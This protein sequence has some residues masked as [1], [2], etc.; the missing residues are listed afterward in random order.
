MHRR[1]RI[2]WWIPWLIVL[3]LMSAPAL[4]TAQTPEPAASPV[5]DSSQVAGEWVARANDQRNG[6]VG[7]APLVG[8]PEILWTAER[9]TP[10]YLPPAVGDDIL[11]VQSEDAVAAL[12]RMTGE[13]LWESPIESSGSAPSLVDGV[14]YTGGLQ[15]A[16]AI[17]AR[18]GKTIWTF[19]PVHELEG[20]PPADFLP[21]TIVDA[22]VAVINGTVF[23]SGGVYGGLW[24]LDAA[25]GQEK[26]FYDT[27]GGMP[28]V[29]S[30]VDGTLYLTADS[31][32]LAGMLAGSTVSRLQA[33]DAAT[34]ELA[35]STELPP[36]TAS[37]T[38]PIVLGDTL[39]IGVSTPIPYIGS[40][41][42]YDRLTGTLLWNTPYPIPP[43]PANAAAK[44]GLFFVPGA[45][46]G[47]V[48]ALDAVT[49]DV[50][51][52]HDSPHMAWWGMIVAGDVLY[53][54]T[55]EPAIEALDTATGALLWSLPAGEP[56]QPTSGIAYRDGVLYSGAGTEV[57]AI[58]GDGGPAPA[59]GE[60]ALSG[61]LPLD[62]DA[63]SFLQ[64]G[65]VLDTPEEF[66]GPVGIAV[67]PNGEIFVIDARNDRIQIF[68]ADGEFDRIWPA[69]G[70]TSTAFSFHEPDGF[71]FGDLAFAA[72]GSLYV[73]DPLDSQIQMFDPDLN[74]TGEFLLPSVDPNDPS[75]PSGIA[76]DEDANRLYVADFARSNVF[77]FDLAGNHL[78]TWGPNG[79]DVDIPLLNPGDVT[80]GPDGNVYVADSL[81]SRIRVL[82]PDGETVGVWG[83]IGTGPGQ[84]AGAAAIAFD[85]DGNAYVTDYVGNRIQVIS[86]DGTVIGI[87]GT[88]GTGDGE[89]QQPTYLAFAPD[90][91]LFVSD[92]T[93]NRVVVLSTSA[94]API[95]TPLAS[96]AA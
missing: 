78:A 79:G 45:D 90:G 76:L 4:A 82:T 86:P 63:G 84:F 80:V 17:D 96:P 60:P 5:L 37:F 6:Q 19:V 88:H 74:P 12:D 44:D 18:D 69:D 22:S 77:V 70:D 92:E 43:W 87:L 67:R 29:V 49:G 16:V 50:V 27:D 40:W 9:G 66:Q 23:V 20:T 52:Q 1:S 57:F 81:R 72:D 28:A 41:N 95:A 62:P 31:L 36:E 51:W 25:T 93:N 75:R 54:R 91:R 30:Y 3:A 35:W 71:F 15:G 56:D 59:P 42:A 14:I 61:V 26:W 7:G 8:A 48:L 53:V 11:V 94:T 33:V 58:S 32:D 47:G 13:V 38:T 21:Q 65:G 64:W 10:A 85:A 2:R 68:S 83:G 24:A 55:E 89:L 34:G 46:I 73:T 39:L